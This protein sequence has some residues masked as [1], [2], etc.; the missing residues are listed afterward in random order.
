MNN[1]AVLFAKRGDLDQARG[2]AEKAVKIEPNYTRGHLTLGSIY[3][4]MNLSTR[5]TR[6]H[7]V[8]E[9]DPS[10]RQR[11]NPRQLRAGHI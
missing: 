10:I 7:K 3:G 8:L 4:N 9:I 11:R 2:F 1:L 6:V 5:R